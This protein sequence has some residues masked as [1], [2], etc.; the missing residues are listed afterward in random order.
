MWTLRRF[1]DDT[2]A[3]TWYGRAF[4]HTYYAVSPTLVRLFGGTQWFRALWRG[5]L[6]RM[7]QQLQARGV[8]SS[9]YQ[10]RSW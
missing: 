3:S 2:L 1:R 4:I 9:P 10:D 7:V 8:E 5:R 6:D